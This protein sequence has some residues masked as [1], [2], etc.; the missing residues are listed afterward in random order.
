MDFVEIDSGAET[1]SQVS[2]TLWRRTVLT[3][4]VL[5]ACLV[6]LAVLVVF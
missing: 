1:A 6:L 2:S 5:A 4:C 3:S